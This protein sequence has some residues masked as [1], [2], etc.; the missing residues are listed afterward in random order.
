ME[1]ERFVGPPGRE[2]SAPMPTTPLDPAHADPR[3]VQ[4]DHREIVLTMRRL[5]REETPILFTFGGEGDVVHTRVVEV[6][7]DGR[8]MAFEWGHTDERSQ[9]VLDA[10]TV[11]VQAELDNV[12]LH[13]AVEPSLGRVQYLKAFACRVPDLMMRVQRREYYRLPIEPSDGVTCVVELRHPDGSP[14]PVEVE[15]V[16]L[17]GGGMSFRLPLVLG[18]QLRLQA[19]LNLPRL[20]LPGAGELT[21]RVRV[22]NLF[23]FPGEDG[24]S[25]VRAGCQFLDLRVGHIAQVQRFIGHI[26]RAR[27]AEERERAERE[28]RLEAAQRALRGRR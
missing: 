8:T 3:F 26:E 1:G 9:Q 7:G 15:L 19:E 10:G 5:Q 18:A 12:R 23:R 21:T 16:D 28:A 20:E 25:W 13:F 22:R 11:A 4:R 17:S 14:R 27:R 6:A 24:Q 2:P